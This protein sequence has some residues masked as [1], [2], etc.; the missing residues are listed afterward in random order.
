MN[1]VFRN[2]SLLWAYHA[3]NS[4][5]GAAKV[6]GRLGL[7]LGLGLWLGLWLWL[8]LGLGLINSKCGAAKVKGWGLG[9][10]RGW[11]GG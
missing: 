10:D 7:G 6:K 9:R 1:A 3:I 5:C 8:W 4:K 2:T 11:S